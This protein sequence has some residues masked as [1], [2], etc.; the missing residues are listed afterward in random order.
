MITENNVLHGGNPLLNNNALKKILENKKSIIEGT[1]ISSVIEE[2]SSVADEKSPKDCIKCKCEQKVVNQAFTFNISI[3]AEPNQDVRSLADA[4]I[5][6]IREKADLLM[7]SFG[8][9]KLSPAS[10]KYSKESRWSTIECVS[11]APLLQNIGQGVENIDLEGIIYLRNF[12]GLNQLKNLKETEVPH[13]LVD[14]AGMGMKPEFSIEG[15]KDHVI[16]IHLTDESGTIDDVAEVCVNYE[17]E[18]VDVPNE[19]NIALGYRETGVLP[20]VIEFL[21]KDIVYVDEIGDSGFTALGYASS[22]GCLKVVKFLVDE[23]ANM[24]V[25][26]KYGSTALHNAAHAG[27]SMKDVEMALKKIANKID[28]TRNNRSLLLSVIGT[29]AHTTLGTKILHLSVKWNLGKVLGF[30][31]CCDIDIN[32]RDKKGNTALHFAA[33][34]DYVDIIQMLMFGGAEINVQNTSWNT[35]LHNAAM[36][37]HLRAIQMLLKFNADPN[38]QNDKGDTPVHIIT[39]SCEDVIL[40]LL[41]KKGAM[42]NIKNEDGDAPLHNAASCNSVCTAMTLLYNRAYVDLKTR[43]GCTALHIAVVK[44]YKE[45][46]KLLLENGANTKIEFKLGDKKYTALDMALMNGE[47]E[48]IGL[49]L[50]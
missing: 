31:I 42:P 46:V 49:L 18:D 23:E 13:S 2:K 32:A 4:V 48:I 9:H 5:K 22:S 6:R 10:I 26:S 15:I 1:K 43:Y 16:S 40:G 39:R 24:Y 35:P 29:I 41:L 8:P 36:N 27:V 37:R 20:M 25:T 11:K 21:V 14:N 30:L 17:N 19:L 34:Y 45:I 28:R 12:N 3:K 47:K 33:K 38:M 44:G 50:S 7:L